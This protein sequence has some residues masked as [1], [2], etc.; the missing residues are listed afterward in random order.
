MVDDNSQKQDTPPTTIIGL[1]GVGAR[2]LA[3]QSFN[4]VLLM[5]IL[6]VVVAGIWQAALWVD[7]SIP[8]HLEMIQVGYEKIETRQTEQ[9]ASQQQAFEKVAATQQASNERIIELITE[10]AIARKSATASLPSAPTG[11][12]QN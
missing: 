3:G 7:R 6:A 9:L 2:W 11:E 12:G 8:K 1:A 4:N 10:K 5:L